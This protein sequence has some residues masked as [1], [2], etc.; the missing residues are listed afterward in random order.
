VLVD[1]AIISILKNDLQSIQQ[2]HVWS[3]DHENPLVWWA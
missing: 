1:D 2:L 3:I